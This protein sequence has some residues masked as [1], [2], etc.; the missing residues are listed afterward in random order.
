MPGDE[1]NSPHSTDEKI[2]VQRGDDAGQLL[3][4]LTG[5][6]SPGIRIQTALASPWL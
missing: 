5:V 3:Y 4:W 1:T 6:L 2:E